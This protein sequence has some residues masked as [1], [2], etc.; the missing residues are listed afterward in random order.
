LKEFVHLK[1]AANNSP[2]FAARV[3]G[4]VQRAIAGRASRECF[5]HFPSSSFKFYVFYHKNID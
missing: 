1:F 2:T 3:F 4:N 5:P